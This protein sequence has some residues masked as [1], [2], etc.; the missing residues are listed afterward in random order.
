MK[1]LFYQEEITDDLFAYI[2]GRSYGENCTVSRG[3]LVCLHVTHTGFDGGNHIGELIVN[4]ELAEDLLDIFRKLYDARYPIEKMVLIDAYD[5]DDER[6]MADN[7]SS[8]F[9][10]R[11]ISHTN[12]LSK[13]SYGR[14]VDINPLYNPYIKIV[15]EE[16]ICQPANASVYMEREKEFPYKITSD[17]LCC[18]LFKEHGFIWGGDWQE[19]KDYQHF[20]K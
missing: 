18:R 5:G 12:Q 13:H 19:S 17:D 1:E 3:S 11:T 6:S 2:C 10:Y 4:R 20:E 14:A 16:L 7:N 9:N 8:A 15:D